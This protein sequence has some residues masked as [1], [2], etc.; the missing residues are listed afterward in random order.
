MEV[1][2]EVVLESI[3]HFFRFTFAQQTVVDKYARKL[4]TDG[5]VKDRSNNRRINAT[6]QAAD[7]STLADSCTNRG[8]F[9]FDQRTDLPG[10]AAAADL[11]HEIRNQQRTID[12]VS[13]F[14]MELHPIHGER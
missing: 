5:L 6:R 11:L 14:G 4:R 2:L 7:H 8:D 3:A 9:S 1:C 13:H 12:G 10:S